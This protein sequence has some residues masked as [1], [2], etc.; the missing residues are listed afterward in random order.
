MDI[1]DKSGVRGLWT[2]LQNRRH[3]YLS[4][5]NPVFDKLFTSFRTAIEDNGI[6]DKENT[7]Y[8]DVFDAFRLALRY[9]KINQSQEK[10]QVVLA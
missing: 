8:N 2:L 7:S 6:L 4:D 10:E 9:Y 5:I 3:F 1:M